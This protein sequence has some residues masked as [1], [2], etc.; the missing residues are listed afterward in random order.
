[1]ALEKRSGELEMAAKREVK[2]QA[3]KMSRGTF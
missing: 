1:M 2:L 3:S